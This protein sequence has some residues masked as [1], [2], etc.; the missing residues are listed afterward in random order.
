MNLN[1]LTVFHSAARLLNFTRAAEELHLT[2]PGISKHLKELEEEYGTKLFERLG[3]KLLLTHGGEILLSAT[4]A[5]FSLLDSA[6]MQI[7]DLG[8]LKSGRLS[9]GATRTIAS[10]LLPDRLVSF[11]QHYP[12]IEIRVETALSRQ[13]TT[14]VLEGDLDIGLVGHLTADPRLAARVFL[15]DSLVLVVSPQHPWAMEKSTIRLADIREQPML[16]SKRGSG[17]WRSLESLLNTSEHNVQIVELGTTEAVKKGVMANLGIALLSG[18][19]LA[20][21]LAGGELVQVAIAD[22]DLGRDLYL[23]QHKD[24]YL[25]KAAQAFFELL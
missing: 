4:E 10:Y 17:T 1:R 25:S 22:G 14:S 18:H 15:P 9:I 2:Q 5:A 6:R 3:K 12:A 23:I 21:E 24:R 7:N 11:R 19:V 20:Q 16:I 13:I 8:D